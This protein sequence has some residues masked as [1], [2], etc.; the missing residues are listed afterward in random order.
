[1]NRSDD[2]P[3]IVLLKKQVNALP[4]DELYKNQLLCSI[5]IY[6][7]QI[8][9]RPEKPINDGWN[10]LEALQQVTLGDVLERSLTLIP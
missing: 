8:L 10:D 4:V 5:E 2:H 6:R 3:R 1:M 7:C 9:E